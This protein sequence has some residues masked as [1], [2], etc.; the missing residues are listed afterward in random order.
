MLPLKE[1]LQYLKGFPLAEYLVITSKDFDKKALEKL[2]FP[3]WLKIS[4]SEHKA[5][6]GGVVKC[7]NLEELTSSVNSLSKKFPFPLIIQK[8]FKGIEIMLGINQDPTFGK[9][10]VFG[11]GGS[12]V[13]VFKDLS[14]LVCPTTKEELEKSFQE[15]K[16]YKSLKEKNSRISELIKLIEKISNLKIKEADFNPIIVNSKEV[17]IIDTRIEL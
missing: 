12:N 6:L 17:K 5:K 4:S 9:I 15:L 2:G 8:D 14:F 10:I 13:E 3:L 1:S 11:S 7:N 16:I